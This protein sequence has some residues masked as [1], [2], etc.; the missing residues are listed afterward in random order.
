M[1]KSSIA[2]RE[3]SR[4]AVLHEDLLEICG[5]NMLAAMLLSVLIYWTDVKLA[6][7]EQ[8][9]EQAKARGESMPEANLWIWKS[10]EGFQHDLMNDKEGMR[11]VHRSTIAS[12]LKLLVDK[13]LIDQRRNPL[14]NI[15]QTRQYRIE[16]QT[17][18]AA[19][20]ALPPLFD[21]TKTDIRMSEISQSNVGNHAMERLKTDN[22]LPKNRQAIPKITN[23]DYDPKI[24]TKDYNH[25]KG[26]TAQSAIAVAP[27]TPAQKN[28]H[29]DENERA[30]RATDDTAILGDSSTHRNSHPGSADSLP[31]TQDTQSVAPTPPARRGSR[32]P[33][34][35]EAVAV[36]AEEEA[37]ITAVF[38]AFDALARECYR[39]EEFRY[40]RSK[41]ARE[42]IIA[43][44]A[45]KPT[46]EKLRAHYSDL[47][48]RPRSKD[49]FLWSENMSIAAVCRD[50]GRKPMLVV[51][52]VPETETGK[53][54]SDP[55]WQARNERNKARAKEQA[56]QI[57]AK[58]EAREQ[59]A[60][61]AVSR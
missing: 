19:I 58:R 45:N 52:N 11:K 30:T 13:K 14:N 24:T 56:A 33:K 10:H 8:E 51:G 16:R 29:E 31:D 7:Y 53:L 39:N 36:N 50:Y 27:H 57:R 6:S 9:C 5:G 60:K 26:T 15:D 46:L 55:E 34:V 25:E 18:Q 49:G 54:T 2:Y 48:K 23:I 37:R 1:R 61:Y 21:C 59:E 40:D 44:L 35:G 43:F 42:A 32:K 4:V 17:V 3:R 41:A 28:E 20:H 38:D 12:A 22:A 47:F